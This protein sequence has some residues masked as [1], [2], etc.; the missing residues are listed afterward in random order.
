MS[1]PLKDLTDHKHTTHMFICLH[2]CLSTYIH[3][4]KCLKF[5]L[6][7]FAVSSTIEHLKYLKHACKRI[8]MFPC[9]HTHLHIPKCL[10]FVLFYNVSFALEDF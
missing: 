8:H 3:V 10:S 7:V 1:I 6:F 4:P 5:G 2:A 9:M